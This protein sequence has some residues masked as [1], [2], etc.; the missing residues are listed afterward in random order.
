VKKDNKE[1]RKGLMSDRESE[2]VG[3]SFEDDGI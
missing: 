1:E 3:P 2:T